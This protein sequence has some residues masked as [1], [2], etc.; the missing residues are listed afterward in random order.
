MTS[1]NARA[2]WLLAVIAAANRALAE[3]QRGIARAI[4]KRALEIS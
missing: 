2:R 3:G 4:L 1:Q